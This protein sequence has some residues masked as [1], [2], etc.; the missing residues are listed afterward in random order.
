MNY[1]LFEDDSIEVN[2][3]FEESEIERFIK[4]WEDGYG[5]KKISYILNRTP[6]EILLLVADRAEIGYIIPR[7]LGIHGY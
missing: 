2:M 1:H 5:V 3:V 6:L 7:R 4:M